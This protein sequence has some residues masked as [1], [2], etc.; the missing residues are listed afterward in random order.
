MKFI[1][2]SSLRHALKEHRFW[3]FCAALSTDH[4]VPVGPNLRR[5]K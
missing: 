1:S 2:A 5:L 3:A 4:P